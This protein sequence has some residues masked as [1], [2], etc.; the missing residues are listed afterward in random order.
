MPFCVFFLVDFHSARLY[1]HYMPIFGTQKINHLWYEWYE[2][3]A[4]E[5]NVCEGIAMSCVQYYT[6]Y[7][8]L[9]SIPFIQALIYIR[10]RPSII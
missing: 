5:I 4:T 7:D 1:C 6:N 9:I 3:R 8:A 2:L 10:N